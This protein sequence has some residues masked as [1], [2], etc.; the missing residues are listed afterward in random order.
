[1]TPGPGWIK[2]RDQELDAVLE[3][4]D[5]IIPGE[6]F[7][8]AGSSAGAYLAR[9]VVHR[10]PAA[11]DG[12]LLTVPLITA[13]RSETHVPSHVTLVADP[14]IVSGL[15]PDE[16]ESFEIV[17][18]QDRTVLDYVRANVPSPGTG[19]EAYQER[20]HER[21]ETYGFSFDVDAL[22]EPCPAPA[23]IVTGR[24]DS[25]IGYRDAWGILEDFPRGTFAVLDRAGH[26]L[27]VEQLDLFHALA[28][29][30]LD[31]VEE[32][33]GVSSSG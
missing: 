20:I 11:I 18:V 7:V 21:P 14:A 12:V 15:T 16:A 19:D 13:R 1:M 3:F 23:L 26:F 27:G 4:V 10:R 9:G 17:V 24:Q 33:I 30:W 25:V 32:Y 2:N 6:R 29:E 22:P 5:A 8:V 31:R 28:G